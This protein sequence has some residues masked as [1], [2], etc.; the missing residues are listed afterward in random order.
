M[1]EFTANFF[2]MTTAEEQDNYFSD[3][4]PSQKN[5]PENDTSPIISGTYRVIDGNLCRIVSG[6]ST[7]DVLKRLDETTKTE[8]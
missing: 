2:S 7:N 4:I 1:N 6:L 5:I 3:D 8:P